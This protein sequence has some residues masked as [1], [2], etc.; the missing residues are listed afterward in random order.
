MNPKWEKEV[1]TQVYQQRVKKKIIRRY[2]SFLQYADGKND[3]ENISNLLNIELGLT[4]KI[5]NILKKNNL[6]L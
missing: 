4:H 5:Y 3:L 6:F 2:M 1:C